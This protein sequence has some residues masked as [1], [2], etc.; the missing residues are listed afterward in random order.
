M[1]FSS[2]FICFMQA[3]VDLEAWGHAQ[4]YQLSTD[5]MQT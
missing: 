2:N 1:M 3:G 5:V 4:V